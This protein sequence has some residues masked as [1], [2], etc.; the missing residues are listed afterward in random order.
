MLNNFLRNIEHDAKNFKT[1]AFLQLAMDG[2]SVNQS[3][4]NMLYS[5][6]EEDNLSKMI[7]IGSCSK[8]TVYGALKV[9]VTKTEWGIDKIL[10]ALFWILSN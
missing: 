6:L 5:K 4:L 3:V 9:G 8:H 2:P 7:N 10:Q 1:E